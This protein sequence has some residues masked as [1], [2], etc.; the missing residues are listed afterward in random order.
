M[1]M[2]KLTVTKID[3]HEAERGLDKFGTFTARRIVI[4]GNEIVV[5][6]YGNGPTVHMNAVERAIDAMPFI[7]IKVDRVALAVVPDERGGV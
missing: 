5:M 4:D 1:I 6:I 3:P 7:E 2:A